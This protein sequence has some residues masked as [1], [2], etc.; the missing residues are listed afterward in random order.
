MANVQQLENDLS[1]FKTSDV[2]M[3]RDSS[4]IVRLAGRAHSAIITQEMAEDS[5]DCEDLVGQ[6]VCLICLGG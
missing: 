2:V 6:T 5:A 4:G 3:I 1:H